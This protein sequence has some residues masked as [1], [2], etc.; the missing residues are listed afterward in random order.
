[1]SELWTKPITAYTI[2][3]SPEQQAE[4]WMQVWGG[5]TGITAAGLSYQLVQVGVL[6]WR[7]GD[8]V[9]AGVAHRMLQHA[10]KAGVIRYERGRWH[11]TAD[12]VA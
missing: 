1:M 5:R 7:K 12:G 8:R 10:R 4:A 6:R 2:T 9:A 3:V 11:L